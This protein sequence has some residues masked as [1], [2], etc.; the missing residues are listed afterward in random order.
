MRREPEKFVWPRAKPSS[1]FR[2]VAVVV[3]LISALAALAW[4][5]WLISKTDE[6]TATL[7]M[8]QAQAV[9]TYMPSAE[10][11]ASEVLTKMILKEKTEAAEQPAPVPAP[12]IITAPAHRISPQ[13]L[14]STTVKLNC[15]RL[16]KAY[17]AAELASMKEYKQ[18]CK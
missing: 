15:A 14:P 5:A 12:K 16:S 17:S 10:D 9:P 8:V 4:C 13:A 3:I 7:P 2:N 1:V 6:P 11:R 18:L